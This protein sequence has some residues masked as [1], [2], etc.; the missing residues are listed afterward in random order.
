LRQFLGAAQERKNAWR[1]WIRDTAVGSFEVILLRLLRLTPIDFA[2]W[3]G[4]VIVHGTRYL[5]PDSEKRARKN[6]VVLR[7]QETDPA[8]VD[9]AMMRLWKCVSRTMTEYSIL[10][11][12][13][14]AGR[15]VIEGAEHVATSRA[16]GRPILLAA[17][18]LGNWE[19]IEAAG[20]SL[21]YVG[22]F[23]YERLQNRFEHR[24]AFEVRARF[25]ANPV[26][27]DPSTARAVLRAMQESGGPFVIFVD[28]FIRNRV[29]AP[30]FG[31][32]LRSD[33]NLAYIVRLAAM[34]NAVVIPIYCLRL[35]GGAHF[36][37]TVLPPLEMADSG[38]RKAD[39]AT[40]A[41]RLNALIEPIVRAH[42]DQWYY[43]L[44]F[45]FAS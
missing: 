41:A 17:L 18:H 34:C 4:A 30:A 1:Y 3:V 27:A 12:L 5:Y 14:P 16:R 36:K 20:F 35:G 7:P 10:D 32:Q 43:L 15:I 38:N 42:L 9:A 2:S 25:G 23:I 21:G 40:N 44:D 26:P 29:Q 33:N 8:V 37:V 22:S 39:A 13:A 28:E 11:R 31:R 6:W 19:V 45:D 24:I